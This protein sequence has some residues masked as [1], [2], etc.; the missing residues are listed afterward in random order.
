MHVFYSPLANKK[1]AWN[2]IPT[3]ML[4]DYSMAHYRVNRANR[5]FHDG[6]T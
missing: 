5:R 4:R 3:P 1:A 6:V 2:T